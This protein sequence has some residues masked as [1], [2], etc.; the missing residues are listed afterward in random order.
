MSRLALHLVVLVLV[1]PAFVVGN[2]PAP[3][4]PGDTVLVADSEPDPS[5][6]NRLRNWATQEQ[7]DRFHSVKG[8]S[9]R[10]VL[11]T[12]GHPCSV[13]KDKGGTEVWRYDWGVDWRVFFREGVC[14][15]TYSNDGW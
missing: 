1:A 11:Q 15:D 13:A 10:K 12:L 4:R 9:R 3:P 8:M 7:A 5:K 2:D 14:T 6:A